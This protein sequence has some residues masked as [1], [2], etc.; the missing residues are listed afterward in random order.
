MGC[1]TQAQ[2]TSAL[3]IVHVHPPFAVALSMAVEG[4]IIPIDSKSSYLFRKVPVIQTASTV[5]SE[6]VAKLASEVLRKYKI[7]MLRGHGSF[8]TGPV[9]VHNQVKYLEMW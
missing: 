2:N 1:A 5:G 4:A 8:S 9:L 6:D 7:F 3:A